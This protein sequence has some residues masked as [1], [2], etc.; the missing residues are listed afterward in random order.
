MCSFVSCIWCCIL[1]ELSPFYFLVVISRVWRNRTDK[2]DPNKLDANNRISTSE[3]LQGTCWMKL[4]VLW[5]A[6]LYTCTIRNMGWQWGRKDFWWSVVTA[7]YQISP[8]TT[9]KRHCTSLCV[10][11]C[12]VLSGMGLYLLAK[13]LPI[14]FDIA[15]ASYGC[16]SCISFV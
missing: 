10:Q 5:H 11:Q 6:N 8:W 3:W 1:L 9:R 16:W 14:I 15:L 2:R 4:W 12:W 7:W 13:Q